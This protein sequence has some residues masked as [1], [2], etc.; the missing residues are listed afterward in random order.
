MV[1]NKAF[2]IA[3]LSDLHL[4][5]TD[6]AE[7]T[8]PKLFGK[9]KGMNEAFRKI[10]KTDPIQ[11][12]DLVLVTGDVADR[13]DINSWQ[14]FW[15]AADAARIA[16]RVA[17]LPGNHD[18]CCLNARMLLNAKKNYREE[19]LEKARA[20]LR[21]GRKLTKLDYN[22][23][24]FPWSLVPDPRVVIFGLN[25]NNLGNYGA[26]SNA[27]GSLGYY[28]LSAL[29]SKLHVHRDIPVKIIALHHSPNIP[30]TE[31]A[32][33][34]G[35]RAFNILERYTHEIPEGQ[36]QALHLLCITHRVR[37]L[38]HGHLHMAEDR[39]IGGV[40]IVG[41]PSTTEPIRGRRKTYQ[42]YTYTV[43]GKGGRVVTRLQTVT[44]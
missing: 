26:I 35:T 6:D 41:V 23:L 16:D 7:R 14:V 39:D 11:K 30:G 15:G 20:G 8:E 29:A 2:S 44:V 17:V 42:F 25:S 9:L 13:G 22:P 43:Q 5:K 28:Q 19:D 12:S 40:R 3:H 37:L 4:T 10:L 21:L 34:R 32:R 38:V 31:T 1:K 24:K 27:M 36:R 18:V 33:R